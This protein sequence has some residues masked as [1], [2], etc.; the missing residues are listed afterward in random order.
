MNNVSYLLSLRRIE[1]S[2]LLTSCDMKNIEKFDFKDPSLIA[3]DVTT[4]FGE[5]LTGGSGLPEFNSYLHT[6]LHELLSKSLVVD[7]LSSLT[8]LIWTEKKSVTLCPSLPPHQQNN[9]RQKKINQ[10]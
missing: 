3:I 7:K 2:I 8:H 6:Y 10:K 5:Y 9:K 4:K 1:L